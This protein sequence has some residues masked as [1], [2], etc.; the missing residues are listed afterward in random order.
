MT[1]FNCHLSVIFAGRTI[2]NNPST[3]SGLSREPIRVLMQRV[4]QGEFSKVSFL[5]GLMFLD[6]FKDCRVSQQFYYSTNLVKEENVRH[7]KE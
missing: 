1:S 3:F 4:E 2:E 5:L 6:I 7:R